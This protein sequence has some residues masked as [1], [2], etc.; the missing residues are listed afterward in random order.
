MQ[1]R[2]KTL[3]GAAAALA[4][5]LTV[6]LVATAPGEP[7]KQQIEDGI[8]TARAAIEHHNASSLLTV[9]SA[10]YKDGTFSN[11][12]QLHY[13]LVRIFRGSGP[14][15]ITT[16]ATAIDVT[17]DSAKSVSHVTIK[18]SDNTTNLYDGN[19]SLTWHR[20]QSHRYLIFPTTVWR[21]TSAD[22]PSIPGMGND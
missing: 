5:A 17:G 15:A 6:Y 12:D 14:I 4:V 22:Y 16:T 13:F 1:Q 2:S 7:D 21:L 11:V 20:E 18:A 19:V 9:V 8:E 3:L 10:D